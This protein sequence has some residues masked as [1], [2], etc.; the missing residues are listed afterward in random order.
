MKQ[1]PTAISKPQLKLLKTLMLKVKMARTMHVYAHSLLK[2]G[3]RVRAARQL[4]QSDSH[5]CQTRH[6]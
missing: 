6:D 4:Q 1:H 2:R 3:R 5:L